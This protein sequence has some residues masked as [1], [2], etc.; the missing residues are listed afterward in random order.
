MG[1]VGLGNTAG[2][3]TFLNKTFQE[4]LDLGRCQI[5]QALG[6]FVASPTNTFRAG[7]LVMKDSSG[8]VIPSDGTDVLGVAKLNH[9][10]NMFSVS[11]DEAV[12]LTGTTASNLAHG[13]VSNVKVSSLAG[14]TG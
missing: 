14:G 12:V 3:G 10:T 6:V 1:S 13:T 5:N 7:M 4:G 2:L 8:L 11:V 9:T